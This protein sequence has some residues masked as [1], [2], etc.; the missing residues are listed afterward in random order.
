MASLSSC[1]LGGEEAID[2]NGPAATGFMRADDGG[3]DED[4]FEGKWLL[5]LT[6]GAASMGRF[7]SVVWM[8]S[9]VLLSL[10]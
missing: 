5:V 4:E 3:G 9:R 2:T 10:E 7:V 1:F 6:R 8:D